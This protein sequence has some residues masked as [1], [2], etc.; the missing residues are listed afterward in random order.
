MLIAADLPVIDDGLFSHGIAKS[1][2]VR[3]E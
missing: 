3:D 2:P 1:V